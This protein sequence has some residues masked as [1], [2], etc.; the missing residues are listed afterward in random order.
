M[1]QLTE[2][3]FY[4]YI[5]CPLWLYFDEHE[6]EK[7]LHDPLMDRLQEDGLIDDLQRELISDRDFSEVEIEDVEEA[8]VKTVELMKEGV[9]TIYHGVLVHGHWVGRP[10]VM[11]KVQGKSKLGDHYY[12]AADF[13]RN[14]R[15][16]KEYM[17]Q[18]TFY[19]E[20]LRL[21]QGAKP[22]QGYVIDPDGEV[23]EY[24][25]EDFETKFHL[26]LDAIERIMAGKRP[27]HFVTSGCKQSPWHEKCQLEAVECNDVSLLSR[28]FTSEIEA[29]R[30]AG[31]KNISALSK[32]D[33]KELEKKIPDLASERL[34]LIREQA[35]ALTQEKH[36]VLGP[37]KFPP[38]D[39]ELYFD[40]E[41][42]PLRDIDY[43]FGVLEVDGD[44]S[45]YHDFLA[46]K[47]EDEG[48][49]W[50]EFIDF[51]RSRAGLPTYHYGWFEIEVV[52]RLGQKYGTDQKILSEIEN[53]MIDL[54][55][56]I[57]EKIIFPVYFY[58]LKDIAQYLGFKWRHPEAS[59][60]N[61]VLWFEEYLNNRRKTSVLKRV[62]EYNED[63][64][65]ATWL[66]KKW[67]AEQDV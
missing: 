4:K 39:R 62:V 27:A 64:V 2:K 8:F 32:M 29:L 58:S 17:F 35:T 46:K 1:P 53:N 23:M 67:C 63:D 5:K 51:M 56:L 33:I 26:S 41:S 45:T 49:A 10:D 18:G 42:D 66:V 20:L 9:Q 40:I 30:K 61:S 43:L 38:A 55:P 7:K 16:R 6:D 13:K 34:I 14:R 12:V 19:A 11:E 60:A 28:V 31:I 44:K 36:V 54:L 57:R 15:L 59:G 22:A 52:R 47:P 48:K 21:I 25:I 24:L 3:H 65:R 37:V 50:Q